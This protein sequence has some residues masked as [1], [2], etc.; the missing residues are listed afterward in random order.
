MHLFKVAFF[1]TGIAYSFINPLGIAIYGG[2][3]LTYW[4]LS[5]LVGG[6]SRVSNAR[7]VAFGTWSEPKEGNLYIHEEIRVDKVEQFLENNYPK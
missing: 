1:A 6:T 3:L 7:K 4:V 5:N 2:I